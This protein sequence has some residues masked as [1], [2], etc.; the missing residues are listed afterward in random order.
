MLDNQ[1]DLSNFKT[2]GEKVVE[3]M[4]TDYSMLT[5]IFRCDND[6]NPVVT[7]VDPYYFCGGGN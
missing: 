6:I 2:D 5:Q 4:I 7:R 3:E 1:T